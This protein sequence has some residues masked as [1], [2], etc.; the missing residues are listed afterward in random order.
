[1]V[2]LAG[3]Y[4]LSI[5]QL[6]SPSDGFKGAEEC[7]FS[8]IYSRRR[9]YPQVIGCFSPPKLIYRRVD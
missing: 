6:P 5:L 8:S 2:R 9:K 1:L 3:V 7:K 4:F